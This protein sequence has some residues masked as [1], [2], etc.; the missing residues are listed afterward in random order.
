ML[1]IDRDD[2]GIPAGNWMKMKVEMFDEDG[3][4]ST[5]IQDSIV[6]A[7]SNPG[8]ASVDPYGGEP[9]AVVA[10]QNEDR[11]GVVTITATHT[12]TGATASVELPV[13][14]NPDSIDTNVA[15]SNLV[16]TVDMQFVDADGNKT[17]LDKDTGFAV[18]APSEVEVSHREDFEKG[19]GAGSF[20]A[21]ADEA[22][23][24]NLTVVS[25]NGLSVTFPVTFG[26]DADV[27][28]AANVVM[29]I[30]S[31]SFVQDGQ[32]GSMDVAPFI[33]DGRTFVPVRFIAEAFGVEAD[34]EPKDDAVEKVFL[35]SDD[36]EV[37]ITIGE[38]TIEVVKGDETETV[39]SDVAAFIRD[40]R[41][42]LPLRAIGEILGAEFD[43]GPKDADTEW[44]SFAR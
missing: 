12:D 36:I 43:W 42:F 10:S 37:T 9:M 39:V 13:V 28:G 14:G 22:G 8:L 19:T 44:V 5:D 30:G 40:G 7:T 6:L 32:P 21:T 16:A 18:V 23:T 15:V 38:Y 1:E 4:K 33:E 31:T 24:Y 3:V 34:W 35:T 11:R 27:P 25:N 2:K 29:F 26:D 17:F 20:R 41:T